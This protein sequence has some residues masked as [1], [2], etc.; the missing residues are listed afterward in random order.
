MQ[1]CY[2]LVRQLLSISRFFLIGGLVGMACSRVFLWMFDL[3]QLQILQESLEAHLKRNRLT[4]LQ[5]VLQ[6]RP[7]VT[8][9]QILSVTDLS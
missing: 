9:K 3:A 8:L 5:Y 4:S 2:S 1:H 6:V 7:Q